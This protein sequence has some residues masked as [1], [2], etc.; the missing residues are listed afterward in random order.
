[1]IGQQRFFRH[2]LVVLQLEPVEHHAAQ[3]SNKDAVLPLRKKVAGIEREAGRRDDRIPVIHRLFQAFLVREALTNWGARV[4][5]AVRDDRPAVILTLLNNV[6]LVAA[7]RAVLGFPQIP[8]SWIERQPFLTARARGTDLR[9][10][11][12]FAQEWMV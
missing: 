8:G 2:D 3:A 4:V 7:A 12:R 10:P 11:A 6:E 9:Q 1:Q 5:D